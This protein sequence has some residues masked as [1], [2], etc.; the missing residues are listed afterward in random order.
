MSYASI[1][2]DFAAANA[3]AQRLEDIADEIRRMTNVRMKNTMDQMS[4][5]WKGGSASA[6]FA[7]AET[8]Q[9]DILKTA[10]QLESVA[11]SIRST[12]RR[13]YE[14]EQTALRLAEQRSSQ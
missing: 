10:V 1:K 13:I 4:A 11:K 2:I 12:A 6:Y 8:L 14:A 3:Q 9:S 5:N 7:K